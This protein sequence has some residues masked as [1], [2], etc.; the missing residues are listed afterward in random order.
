MRIALAVP[1]AFL[2]LALALL[3][4]AANFWF[5]TL[6]ATGQERWLYAFLFAVL[7]ACK[8]LLLPWRDAFLA[9]GDKKRARWALL[10]FLIF[11]LVSFLAEFGL[12][13]TIKGQ[14]TAEVS[15][16]GAAVA[17][18]STPLQQAQEGLKALAPTR[19]RAEIERD[20]AD[21]ELDPL[22][23]RSKACKDV[24]ESDSREFCKAYNG[25]Q[26]ELRRYDERKALQGRIDTL[27]GQL[28]AQASDGTMATAKKGDAQAVSIADLVGLPPA[29]VSNILGLLI[30]LLVEMG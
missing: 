23:R 8:T 21:K 20:I 24:T 1:A 22:W 14:L 6:L 28:L 5:G 2:G 17:L 10:A 11:A 19:Q 4:I 29:T 15:T 25:V 13:K 12:Y 26:A 3:S 30:A 18:V 9:D 16:A 27:R 7:D